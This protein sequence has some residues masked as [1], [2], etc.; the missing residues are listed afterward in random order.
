MNAP[1]PSPPL[2]STGN[3]MHRGN[4]VCDGFRASRQVHLEAAQPSP[5]PVMSLED[6]HSQSEEED[7]D[8]GEDAGARC[9]SNPDLASLH[10]LLTRFDRIYA[11][12]RLIDMQ[13]G[14]SQDSDSEA[15][16]AG[17]LEDYYESLIDNLNSASSSRSFS[18]DP[19]DTDFVRRHDD[20]DDDDGAVTSCASLDD[21]DD[22]D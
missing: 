20:D 21:L 13:A 5:A 18:A 1:P 4:R 10:G 11:N 8:D 16:G 3:R 17:L 6:L 22:V 15:S 9:S 19:S 14:P 2:P 7:D 12:N